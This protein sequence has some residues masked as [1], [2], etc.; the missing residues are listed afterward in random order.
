LTERGGDSSPEQHFYR[1]ETAA[2]HR[3][4]AEIPYRVIAASADTADF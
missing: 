4:L 1:R 3:R 2:C